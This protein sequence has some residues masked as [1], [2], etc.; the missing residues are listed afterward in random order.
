MRWVEPASTYAS[1]QQIPVTSSQKLLLFDAIILK[2]SIRQECFMSIYDKRI[3]IEAAENGY[4]VTVEDEDG[5]KIH[6][7]SRRRQLMHHVGACVNELSTTD[8][9]E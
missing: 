6:V 3:V 1:P 9:D 5:T 4:I 2:Y 8:S 7:F